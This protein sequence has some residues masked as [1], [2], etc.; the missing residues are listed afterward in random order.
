MTAPDGPH[1]AW[2]LAVYGRPGVSDACVRLQDRFGVDVNVLLVA[3]HAGLAMGRSVTPE[4]VADA[5]ARVETLR[6]QV[7]QPLRSV[8]R[9][10]KGAPYGDLTEMV[11]NRVKAS[12]LLAEQMEQALLAGIAAGW[13]AAT[14]TDTAAALVMRVVDHYAAASGTVPDTHDQAA[15]ATLAAAASG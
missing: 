8:R 15:I 12:E 6:R 13:P 4:A 5:D 11:R 14:A 1:W 10:L 7:I 3:L 9:H 2:A